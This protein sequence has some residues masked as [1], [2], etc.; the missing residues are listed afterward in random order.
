MIVERQVV[1]FI[2]VILIFP[3]VTVCNIIMYSVTSNTWCRLHVCSC[4]V[5]VIAMVLVV[6]ERQSRRVVRLVGS[7]LRPLQLS[8]A[9]LVIKINPCTTLFEMCTLHY[10]NVTSCNSTSSSWMVELEHSLNRVL[11]SQVPELRHQLYKIYQHRYL[12]TQANAV[13]YL[14]INRY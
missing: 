5:V 9:L 14:E 3:C 10:G 7:M 11:H 1:G 2:I 12:H 4:S 13:S 6:V 8:F